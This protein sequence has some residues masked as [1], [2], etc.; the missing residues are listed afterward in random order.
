MNDNKLTIE[1][2]AKAYDEAIERAKAYQG[3][4]SEMEIIFPELKESEDEE[5]KEMLK[6][7]VE[8]TP[9]MQDK[10]EKCYEWLEKQGYKVSAIEGFETEF[11]KQV[12]HLIASAI[13]KE[14]EYNQGY[15]KWTANALLNYAK[16]ELEKQGEKKPANSAKTCKDEQKPEGDQHS[17]PTS[18]NSSLPTFDESIYHPCTEEVYEQ[19]LATWSEE[20]EKQAR[21]IERIV[22]DDGCT[23]KLQK[24]I[25]DWLKSLKDRIQPKQKRGEC[26]NERDVPSKELIYNIWSLGNAWYSITK[27]KCA[28]EHGSQIDYIQK[29]WSEGDYYDKF[30]FQ[31][32]WKPSDEQMEA[33]KQA[34]TDAC[35][36]PYFN[37]LAS[38]YINLKGY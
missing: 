34:K 16:N 26:L 33:L 15:I 28:T 35:G 9:W 31:N 1:Q 14:H 5:I 23:Q 6:V 27:G 8:R 29:H 2:K 18:D 7:A 4:R 25:A 19:K 10:K 30:V 20:D 22:H 17:L 13:N 21:Q 32:R 12:S 3:L 24:Q 37:A 38:L 11:E 36:K